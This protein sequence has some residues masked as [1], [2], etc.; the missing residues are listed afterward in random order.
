MFSLGLPS[1]KKT[2]HK[3]NPRCDAGAEFVFSFFSPL[4][5]PASITLPRKVRP[6][7]HEIRQHVRHGRPRVRL[8]GGKAKGHQV[9]ENH[10]W[11]KGTTSDHWIKCRSIRS[12]CGFIMVVN[13]TKETLCPKNGMTIGSETVCRERRW[14]N[15]TTHNWSANLRNFGQPK[16]DPKHQGPFPKKH[17]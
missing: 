17:I 3:R 5:I 2:F 14:A 6:C 8:I 15:Q 12:P 7:D 10:R 9:L 16:H 11:R 1:K 13:I 4:D